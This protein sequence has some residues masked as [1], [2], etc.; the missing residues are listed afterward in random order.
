MQKSPKRRIPEI[1]SRPWRILSRDT[2]GS[3]IAEFAL[4]LPIFFLLLFGIF[5]FGQAFHIYVAI[6]NA[7]RD[8]ARAAVAP[9]CTT[10]TAVDP[11]QSAWNAI[12]NDLNSARINPAL[13]QPPTVPPSLC[14]CS[15]GAVT[16]CDSN[17]V[18]CD[19]LHAANI[20]VQGV[21]HASG[22]AV[23]VGVQLSSTAAASTS[24]PGGAG[25]CGVSVSFQYPVTFFL[26]YTTLNLRMRAQ[27]EARA[28][29]TQ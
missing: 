7:A 1:V 3:E 16:T 15:P 12:Q 17:T 25:E 23:S 28:E 8:G 29:A 18:G 4:T 11:A 24:I 13:L 22:S 14:A 9:A 5:W 2:G 26:P 19:G 27:A 6:T 10:C 21:S 20:C